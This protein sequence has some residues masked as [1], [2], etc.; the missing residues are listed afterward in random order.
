[1][2]ADPL[3]PNTSGRTV[4]YMAAEAGLENVIRCILKLHPNIDVNAPITS[5][6]QKYCFTHV[7]AR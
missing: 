3:K 4:L 7:A 2:G 5:E 6:H 1:M